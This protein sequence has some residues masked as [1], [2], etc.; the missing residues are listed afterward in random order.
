M[1]ITR[2][3]FSQPNRGLAIAFLLYGLVRFM[4]YHML[5]NALH[6][7]TTVD[8]QRLHVRNKGQRC[9]LHDQNLGVAG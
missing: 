4:G 6:T 1:I 5:D 7:Q 8:V 2:I 9:Q 3:L